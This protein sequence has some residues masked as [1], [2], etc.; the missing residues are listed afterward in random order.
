MGTEIWGTPGI[1]GDSIVIRVRVDEGDIVPVF[2]GHWTT[3]RAEHANSAVIAKATD[4]A[5]AW[6]RDHPDEAHNWYSEL[7][8]NRRQK[9]Q[10]KS[11]GF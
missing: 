5:R 4:A 1:E 7:E 3:T 6:L 9:E 2:I 8:R 11:V 10:G